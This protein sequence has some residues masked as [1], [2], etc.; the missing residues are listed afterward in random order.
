MGSDSSIPVFG[1]GGVKIYRPKHIT[2]RL[3]AQNGYFTIHPLESKTTRF[4]PLW[5]DRSL[6]GEFV[7][8]EIPASSFCDLRDDLERLG[9]SDLTMFPDLDGV[10]RF[11]SW[12]ASLLEDEADPPNILLNQ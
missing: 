5:E 10:C 8:V 2:E 1:V 6:Q 4:T 11:I 12:N 3:I 9:V 7:K